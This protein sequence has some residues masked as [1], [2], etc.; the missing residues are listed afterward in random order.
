MFSLKKRLNTN[1]QSGH[2]VDA[3]RLLIVHDKMSGAD[4]QTFQYDYIVNND[5]A[6]IN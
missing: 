5:F 1:Q 6:V 4:A 3:G 2:P